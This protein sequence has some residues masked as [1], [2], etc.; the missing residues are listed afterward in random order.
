MTNE[1]KPNPRNHSQAHTITR[2]RPTSRLSSPRKAVFGRDRC[3]DRAASRWP[4]SASCSR[5]HNDKVL[6]EHTDGAGRAH[7]D[8]AAAQAGRAGRQLCAA[9]QRDRLYRFAH[10]RAHRRLPTRW[11]YDIGAH[12]KK[13]ALLAEIATPELDQ[14]LAQAQAD[15]ATAQANA[16]NAHI[17]AE[18]YS[19]LVKSNA[20]SQPGHRHLREPGRRHRLGGQLRPGQRAAAARTAVV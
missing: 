13:G 16:N 18:R 14:Q 9:R 7:G 2:A 19:D 5:I 6:A 4:S 11:Y 20:V 8:R 12:V 17:Q 15:L 3:A 10:L 1:S